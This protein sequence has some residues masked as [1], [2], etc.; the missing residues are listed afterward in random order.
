[1]TSD[2]PR[3]DA[4]WASTWQTERRLHELCLQLERELA[5]SLEN[6]LKTQAEVK[7][8]R[9]A[10]QSCYWATNTYDGNYTRAC[11]NVATIAIQALKTQDL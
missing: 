4:E 1:M 5:I 3:T 10:L 9:A 7:R 8:L 2:T 6:Q 11:D